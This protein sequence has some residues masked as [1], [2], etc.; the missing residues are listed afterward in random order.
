VFYFSNNHSYFNLR[1][2][3]LI[4]FIFFSIIVGIY[5]II[6]HNQSE[7]RPTSLELI[8]L[9]K[10]FGAIEIQD[11]IDFIRIQNKVVNKIKHKFIG[12]DKLVLQDIIKLESGYCYDRSFVLQK[13]LSHNHIPI[14][15]V[16]IYY[17]PTSSKTN[18]FDLFKKNTLSHNLFEFK[19]KEKWYL[20]KTNYPMNGFESLESYMISGKV[21]PNHSKF[22]RYLN[23][24]NSR[25]LSPNWL[26]DIYY[27]D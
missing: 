14:R 17:N 6:K 23:N 7:I 3:K 22:L 13:I 18:I 20:M 21:V 10:E 4:S 2:F 15:P 19:F 25:F 27:F 9:K 1:Y 24:R 5:L 12:S 16:Y 8:I 11:S 26:P